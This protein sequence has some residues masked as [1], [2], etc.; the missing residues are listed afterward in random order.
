[1]FIILGLIATLSGTALFV[2]AHANGDIG[3][4]NRCLKDGG[5]M[6]YCRNFCGY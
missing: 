6:E 1:M 5:G 2:M 3:C 4:V